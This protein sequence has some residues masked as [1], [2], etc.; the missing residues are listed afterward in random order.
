[1][2]LRY[3]RVWKRPPLDNLEI[4]FRKEEILGLK[5]TIHFVVGINGSGK[6]RMLQVITE[7]LLAL[8]R[9]QVPRFPVTLAYDLNYPGMP[10]QSR[11]I[12]FHSSY[13]Q[14]RGPYQSSDAEMAATELIEFEGLLPEDTDWAFLSGERKI[15]PE[16]L[17]TGIRERWPSSRL[18]SMGLYLPE[19]LLVYTSGALGGWERLFAHSRADTSLLSGLLAT[20]TRQ[21]ERPAGWRSGDAVTITDATDGEVLATIGLW[22]RGEDYRFSLLA[23]MLRQAADEF[24]TDLNTPEATRLFVERRVRARYQKIPLPERYDESIRS[25]LDEVGWLWPLTVGIRT[26]A[27]PDDPDWQLLAEAATSIVREPFPPDGS[28]RARILYFDLR[29]RVNGT[30]TA[31]RLLRALNGAPL[32][33]EVPDAVSEAKSLTALRRLLYWQR[34]GVV[35]SQDIRI[36]LKKM[37]A[38][39][40]LPLEALS[41]GERMFLGRM[42]LLYTLWDSDNSLALL[43]EPETHFNDYWKREIVD[44][45]DKSLSKRTSDVVFTTHSSVALTDAFDKEITLLKRSNQNPDQITAVYPL[46]PTFGASPTEILQEIFDGPR[47]VG[48]RASEFLDSVLVILTLPNEMRNYWAE[49]ISTGQQNI[50]LPEALRQAMYSRFL[51]AEIS[52][53]TSDLSRKEEQSVKALLDRRLQLI[54]DTLLNYGRTKGYAMTGLDAE[55]GERDILSHVLDDLIEKI[56]AGFYLFEFKRRRNAIVKSQSATE[57]KK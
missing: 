55:G 35:R 14:E 22:I 53:G 47:A 42:A 57:A 41:D 36:V 25:V 50:P 38:A 10:D 1:M 48:Q 12:Y 24:D 44:I 29:T 3:L 7:V 45:M 52:E 17:N 21:Q 31:R 5:G 11:T 18:P 16:S 2:R 20:A 51:P 15:S 27:L 33:G 46:P 13:G 30:N 26:T 9:G 43:D 19:V 56:G 49:V 37:G 32:D 28:P 40:P 4:V 34:R 23:A 54:L 39:D 6:S 8:E